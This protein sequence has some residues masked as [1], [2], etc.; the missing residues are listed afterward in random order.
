MTAR[1]AVSPVAPRADAEGVTRRAPFSDNPRVGARGQRTRQRILD[2]AL[3][4]FG[5]EGFHQCSIAR[6]SERASCSRVSF[7]QYFSGKEDVFRS[8][9]G[10]VARQIS[11]S[12]EAIDPLTPDASGWDGLRAWVGRYGD[13]HARYGPIFQGL[14]TTFKDDEGLTAASARLADQSVSR[15]R[16]KLSISDLPARHLDPLIALL[17]ASLS[18]TLDDAATLRAAA[19]EA[20]PRERIEIAFTDVMHRSLFGRNPFNVHAG[21]RSRPPRVEFGPDVGA[22]MVKEEAIRSGTDKR[23]A[24]NA[25]VRNGRDVF[26][27]R[28]YH[29]TRVDDLAAAAGVSHGVFYRYFENK[30][31]LAIVLTVQAMRAV[32]DAFVGIPDLAAGNG[33]ELRRWFRR[34]NAA[35]IGE[36]AMIRVWVEAALEDARMRSLSASA[37]DWGRR[38]MVRVLGTRGAGTGDVDVEAIVMVAVL[39]AFGSRPRGVAAVDAAANVVERGLLSGGAGL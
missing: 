9:A 32:G 37:L 2:A 29:A 14:P 11:A 33:P 8:L 12:T 4:L 23:A 25:L 10:Q 22:M 38:R 20:Y 34:Y 7:Y 26:V 39:G 1:D 27:Q 28:G 31:E 19:P 3:Q 35:Q 24:L 13:I 15:I 36:A 17:I 21:S 16:S 18:R 30:N 5:D 6:I